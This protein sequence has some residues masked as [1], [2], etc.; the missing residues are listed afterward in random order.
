MYELIAGSGVVTG[1]LTIPGVRQAI[2][3]LALGIVDPPIAYA[4]QVSQGIRDDTAAR[5]KI[6]SV[7]ATAA[8]ERV[9]EDP[10]LVDRAR[11]RWTRQ[12]GARQL[13]RE[14]IAAR[15]LD[16]LAEGEPPENVAPPSE[17]FMRVFEDMAEKVSST[18]LA[19]LM[20]RI[21]AGEIRKPGSVSRRTLAAVALLDR[22]IVAALSE[23]RPYLLDGAWVHIPPSEEDEWW[24]RC[25]L[26]SSVAI[27]SEMGGRKLPVEDGIC[28][29]RVG[30]DAMIVTVRR[31]VL[32]ALGPLVVDGLHLTPTGQE[33]VSLLPLPA[34]SKTLEIARGFLEHDFIV[35][36]K[37]GG[38]VEREGGELQVI[39]AQEVAASWTG[40]PTTPTP[41]TPFII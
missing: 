18:E 23:L 12:L 25:W 8:R 41:A 22:E 15:T 2:G 21:L 4:E 20:A 5:K 24:R 28:T 26:L 14:E 27:C 36:A 1:L 39:N 33:L 7:L 38:V 11:D 35:K 29:I 16:V 19:D 30:T 10:E 6:A 17:D 34:E 37:F 31:D 3:R 9:L 13:I 32:A 40:L